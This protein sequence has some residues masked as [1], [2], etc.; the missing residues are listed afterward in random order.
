VFA[1]DPVH[2]PDNSLLQ[3]QFLRFLGPMHP[4]L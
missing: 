4:L 1:S 3:K 2:E